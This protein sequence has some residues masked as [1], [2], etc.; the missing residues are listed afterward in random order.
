MR[1]EQDI[2]SLMEAVDLLKAISNP[3]RLAILCWLDEGEKS[4][5]E[6]AEFSQLSQSALSQHLAGLRSK[7]LVKT[8]RDQQSI[9]YSLASGEL[10]SIIDLLHDLYCNQASS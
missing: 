6:I 9:Y 4:V 2:K 5:G 10:K 1:E 7:K 8:R 3:K